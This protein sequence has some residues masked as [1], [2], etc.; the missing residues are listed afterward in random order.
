[1]KTL[2][3]CASDPEAGRKRESPKKDEGFYLQISRHDPG[4]PPRMK[5]L[6]QCA[7]DPE[8]GRK[9]ESRKLNEAR[10]SNTKISIYR[11]IDIIPWITTKDENT[12]A[13]CKRP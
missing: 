1:M 9:R 3:Q 13:V 5:T 4:S 6:K 10:R 7:S 2:K 8:A 11:S 12:E